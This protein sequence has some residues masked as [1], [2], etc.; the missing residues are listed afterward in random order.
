[1]SVFEVNITL[2]VDAYF[3][4]STEYIK[5][6]CVKINEMREISHEELA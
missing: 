5:Q 3:I 1:M 2:V 6:F 4:S